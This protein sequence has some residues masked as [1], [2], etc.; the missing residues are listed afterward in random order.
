MQ[1]VEALHDEYIGVRDGIGLALNN[2]VNQVG[3]D[4]CGNLGGT[5][6]D[7]GHKLQ[8]GH[9]VVGLWEAL[10][11]HDAA[12]LKLG[13]GVEEPIGGDHLN[14]RSALPAA[15]QLLQQ[16]RNRGFAHRNRAGNPDNKGHAASALAEEVAGDPV[17]F[18]VFGHI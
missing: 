7:V 6:L 18:L 12:A 1:H 15:Q 17:E 5:A 8:Q 9:A 2:V 16:S 13:V 4:R 14:L 10:A 11:V 3:V